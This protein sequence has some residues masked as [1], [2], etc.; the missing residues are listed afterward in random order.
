VGDW[1]N[2]S[3]SLAEASALLGM[4]VRLGCPVGY[5]PTD[6]ELEAV[7]ALGAASVVW[8]PSPEEAMA[9]AHAV[10]TDV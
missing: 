5:A 4:H 8:S 10:H 2:V 7:A 3:R 6:A 9:G 1:N